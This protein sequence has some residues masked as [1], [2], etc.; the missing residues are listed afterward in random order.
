MHTAACKAVIPNS[1]NLRSWVYLHEQL[2]H[3]EEALSQET[4]SQWCIGTAL[5]H[6]Q[7]TVTSQRPYLCIWV[8][9]HELLVEEVG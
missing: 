7:Q 3:Q 2:S 8:R 1:T 5:K 4:C 6:Q 9:L